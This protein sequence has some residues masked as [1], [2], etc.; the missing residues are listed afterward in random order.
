MQLSITCPKCTA[1]MMPVR[2]NGVLIDR[3]S[4]CGGIFL[5]RGEL[6]KIVALEQQRA[7]DW[8]DDGGVRVRSQGNKRRKRSFFEDLLDIG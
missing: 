1:E 5:D 4:E 3:C 7:G 2:R 8:D 6:E